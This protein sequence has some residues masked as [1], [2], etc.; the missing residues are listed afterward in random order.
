MPVMVTLPPIFNNP[1]LNEKVTK[2]AAVMVTDELTTVVS[3]GNDK[4]V[5]EANWHEMEFTD[6]NKGTLTLVTDAHIGL[7][8]LVVE[9]SAGRLS[10][11][12]A[13][14]VNEKLP[15]IEVKL[16]NVNVVSEANETVIAADVVSDGMLRVVN[17]VP[18]NVVAPVM[19]V[20][21]GR[22]SVVNPFKLELKTPLIVSKFGM[23]R[24]VMLLP[25]ALK[26]PI[27]VNAGIERLV[28]G[29]LKENERAPAMVVKFVTVNVDRELKLGL[30]SAETIVSDGRFNVVIFAPEGDTSP[31]TISKFGS[32]MVVNKAV[33]IV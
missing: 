7:K 12:R 6:D 13:A 20:N 29:V 5:S 8:L 2:L 16:V 3:A 27:L 24:V 31:L 30:K 19:E 21:A 14:A 32:D 23:L 28:N 9:T 10:V 4:L 15:V 25:T 22:L 11:V 1:E 17:E 18:V 33:L 26:A